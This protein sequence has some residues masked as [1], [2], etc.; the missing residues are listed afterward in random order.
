MSDFRYD[1]GAEIS[2][3]S[4]EAGVTVYQGSAGTQGRGAALLTPDEA[5]ELAAALTQHAAAARGTETQTEP[6]SAATE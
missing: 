5:D 4:T 1:D 3:N 2:I 6:A